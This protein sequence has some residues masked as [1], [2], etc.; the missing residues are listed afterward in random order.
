MHPFDEL[1]Q[2]FLRFTCTIKELIQTALAV[3]ESSDLDSS[4]T[5][6]RLMNTLIG[7]NSY[8]QGNEDSIATAMEDKI[9]ADYAK[10]PLMTGE[11]SVDDYWRISFPDHMIELIGWEP[12]DT[13]IW[14]EN[15]DG[16]F[17]IRKVV[18]EE[19]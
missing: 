8:V 9:V 16:S 7:L 6:D 17:S 5:S 3:A 15:S 2:R 13:L 18:Q 4:E 14:T 1:E 19:V 11:A 12:G 10:K